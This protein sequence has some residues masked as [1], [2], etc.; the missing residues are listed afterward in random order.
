MSLILTVKNYLFAL[1]EI[2]TCLFN[3]FAG[4]TAGYN[5]VNNYFSASN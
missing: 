1:T 2:S 3:F 5:D 4:A